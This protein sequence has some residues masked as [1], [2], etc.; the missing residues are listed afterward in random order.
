MNHA[1]VILFVYNRPEHT[2]KSIEALQRNDGWSDTDVYVFCDGPRDGQPI[3][4]SII[5]TH[6]MA[7][8]IS[9]SKTLTI[10]KS[11]VNIGLYKNILL[12]VS[13]VLSKHV[14]AIIIED[15]IVV[16]PGF[17]KYMNE[18]LKKYEYEKQIACISGYV[19]PLPEVMKDPFFF[20]G[21]IA[22]V[23]LHGTID[24]RNWRQILIY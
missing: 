23:G 16:L 17:L 15:D 24:G 14:S 9:G 3:S 12:G 13:S 5:D 4:K 20:A 8:S 1:P 21:R 18:A 22:G 10:S 6:A 19:Y 7:E 2:W 11:K